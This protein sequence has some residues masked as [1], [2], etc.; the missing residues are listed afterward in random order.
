MAKKNK[1]LKHIKAWQKQEREI[2]ELRCSQG[3]DK[4]RA[5]SLMTALADREITAVHLINSA[6]A[7]IEKLLAKIDKLKAKLKG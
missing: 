5:L 2:E 6:E 7:E 3:M 1:V 4:D